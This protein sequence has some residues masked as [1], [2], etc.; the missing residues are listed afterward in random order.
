MM[1]YLIYTCK[2]GT[3]LSKETKLAKKQMKAEKKAVKL[4]KKQAVKYDKLVKKI[5]KKNAKAE[6]KAQ[7]K[8]KPFTPVAIPTQ[9]EAFAAVADSKPKQIIKLVILVLLIVY[10]IYFLVMWFQYVAPVK[11]AAGEEEKPAAA[12]TY[13]RYKNKHKITTTPDY[14]VDAAKDLL[15]QVIHDNW[16]TIGYGS[17][18]SS[19]AIN[20]SGNVV[21]IN[22]ADCYIFSASGKKYAVAVKLSAVYLEKNGEYE[23]LT[24]HADNYLEFAQ[25]SNK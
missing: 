21:N 25:G 8:G 2:E 3:A 9:E 11:N 18:P 20:Y 7:K 19:S 24:F 5:N 12:A 1:L 22:N 23:P 15:K 6:A 10:V 13:D 14:S 4:E 16:Q 17:D